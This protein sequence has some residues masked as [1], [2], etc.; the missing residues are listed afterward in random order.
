MNVLFI[1][2]KNVGLDLRDM[3]VRDVNEKYDILMQK[4]KDGNIEDSD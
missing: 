1:A 3:E 4:Q 2:N